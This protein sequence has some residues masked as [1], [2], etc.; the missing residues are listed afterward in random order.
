MRSSGS[1]KAEH[2]TIKRIILNHLQILSVILGLNVPWPDTLLTTMKALGSSV[3]GASYSNLVSCMR[4]HGSNVNSRAGAFYL[5]LILSISAV[6]FAVII[7]GIYW[8]RRVY[9]IFLP[10]L[11]F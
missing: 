6:I 4:N 10:E 3:T 1:R 2:S 11:C 9:L 7:S 5:N 8:V